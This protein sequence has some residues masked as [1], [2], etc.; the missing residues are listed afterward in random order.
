[1]ITKIS[2]HSFNNNLVVIYFSFFNHK[3]YKGSI[4]FEVINNEL[5]SDCLEFFGNDFS[6]PLKDIIKYIKTNTNYN[7]ITIYSKFDNYKKF[8]KFLSNFN[9]F[10]TDNKDYY[11]YE[12]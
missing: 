9:K 7:K 1:M 12:F 3:H 10:T 4:C 11:I 8:E 5:I 6:K 2:I